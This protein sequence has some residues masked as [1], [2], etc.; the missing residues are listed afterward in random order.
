MVTRVG[1]RLIRYV[2]ER[3]ASSQNFRGMDA[4]ARSAR[5]VSTM[6]RYLRSADPFC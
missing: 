5:P 6:W 2:A 4:C 1:M 3:K